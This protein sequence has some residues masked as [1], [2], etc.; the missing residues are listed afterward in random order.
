MA[1][2]IARGIELEDP[3]VKVKLFNSSKVDKNDIITEVFKSKGIL[4][5]APTVN[6]G[7]LHSIAGI[8]EMIKGMKFQDKYL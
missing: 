7:Y 8:I 1:E 2:A 6:N 4:L 5:G 3:K